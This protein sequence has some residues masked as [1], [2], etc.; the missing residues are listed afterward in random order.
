MASQI[1]EPQRSIFYLIN[2]PVLKEQQASTEILRSQ[3]T[4]GST[5]VP[6]K[7]KY[8]EINNRLVNLKNRLRNNIITPVNYADAASHLLHL[9]WLQNHLW[10]NG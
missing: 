1:E 5:P 8:V 10:R 7:T 4:A 2:L 3:Y 9:E 6:C